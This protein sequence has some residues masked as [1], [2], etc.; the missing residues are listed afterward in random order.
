MTWKAKLNE[1]W[2]WLI[3]IDGRFLSRSAKSVHMTLW[4]GSRPPGGNHNWRWHM[5]FPDYIQQLASSAT[6]WPIVGG[7]RGGKSKQQAGT[8]TVVRR[9]SRQ[10]DGFQLRTD[11]MNPYIEEDIRA[12][13]ERERD[14]WQ[15][16]TRAALRAQRPPGADH[17][18]THLMR[19]EESDNNSSNL[20]QHVQEV[21]GKPQAG[22]LPDRKI[23]M[24]RGDVIVNGSSIS[25]EQSE[26]EDNRSTKLNTIGS[27]SESKNGGFKSVRPISYILCAQ[28]A[29]DLEGDPSHGRVNGR[30]LH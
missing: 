17:T 28:R 9:N 19:T 3:D 23:D 29:A 8:A 10:T 27:S 2:M 12:H 20:G 21:Q 14:S 13:Q 18:D 5:S 1:A 4:E 16:R 26:T 11:D 6:F 24:E 30:P 22:M 15:P 7:T 25:S